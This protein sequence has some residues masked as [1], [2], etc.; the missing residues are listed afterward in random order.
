MTTPAAARPH[1]RAVPLK[2]LRPAPWNPRTLRDERFKNLCRSIEADPE[3]LWLRPILARLDGEVF[4][5]NMRLR[6]AAHLG[7]KTVP[8]ILLDIPEQLAKERAL[9]DNG[10]WGE[11]ED[12]G[13]IALL[14]EL[15]AQGS[16]MDLLGFAD[17]ELVQFLAKRA[18]E[19]LTDPDDVPDPPAEPVTQRGDLWICGDHRILCGDA[20]NADDVARVMGP[21]TA[22]MVWTDPPYGV[23][24]VSR[25]GT[26]GVA[27]STARA[28]GR[29]GQG[30]AARRDLLAAGNNGMA[31]D[32]LD[33]DGL[34]AFL[35]LAFG[36]ILR[37]TKPGAA[38]YVCAP[39]NPIGLAFSLALTRIGV[40][41][42][43]LVWVKSALVLG[44]ADYHY[45]HEPI[46]YG[47]SPGAAHHPVTDRSQDTV[48]E[49]DRPHA[50][51]EHPTMKPVALVQRGIVNSSDA[52]ALVLDPFLGSGTTVIACEQLG[53]RCYG[54][55]IEPKYTEIAVRRWEN[56]TGRVA[57]RIPAAD[58]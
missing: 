50:S 46:Y 40:W 37:V 58:A 28:G 11:W 43:S 13:L 6:A 3:F 27:N 20:T 47:W 53:R 10:S 57:E 41:R 9:R 17:R 15:Q 54:I 1:V 5:G 31:N 44:R 12:E 8:A 48:W 21:T 38:W 39:H 2:K 32:D 16:A 49:F 35:D 14:A 18:T 22:D 55:E 52:G 56:F 51:P 24:I 26:T 42:H 34:T 23:A 45:R 30:A 29:V 4:G 33:L 7:W 25:T 19:G 36:N